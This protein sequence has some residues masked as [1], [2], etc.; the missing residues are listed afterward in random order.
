MSRLLW[1]TH[2]ATRKG[3]VDARHWQ[4]LVIM[5]PTGTPPA[6]R[7]A[8]R[9]PIVRVHQTVPST[10]VR[11]A[12]VRA[13]TVRAPTVPSPN[14]RM[15]GTVS[16]AETATVEEEGGYDGDFNGLDSAFEADGAEDMIGWDEYRP[17]SPEGDS[18]AG[19]AT[20]ADCPLPTPRPTEWH[21]FRN[22]HEA[23]V[24]LVCVARWVRLLVSPWPMSRL[25]RLTHALP[26]RDLSRR[27]AQAVAWTYE[28]GHGQR[29]P[30]L[31]EQG[32]L[33]MSCLGRRSH[34]LT[35]RSL[36]GGTCP[37]AAFARLT[38]CHFAFF[39]PRCPKPQRTRCFQE[40]HPVLILRTKDWSA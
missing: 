11:V 2:T 27:D 22:K 15:G 7:A 12:A 23:T 36:F 1:T 28:M 17:L 29:I 3:P 38:L 5:E 16:H 8:T 19:Q 10:S 6:K 37:Q 31:G 32:F 14:V 9:E 40:P 18:R 35:P 25:A 39:F 20:Q 33:A 4:V 30:G 34:I 24:G 21:P 13:P 26:P